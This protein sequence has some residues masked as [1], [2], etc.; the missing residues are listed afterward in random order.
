MTELLK[1]KFES[2]HPGSSLYLYGSHALG[3]AHKLSDIDLLVLSPQNRT[4]QQGFNRDE[5][6]SF[7][8]NYLVVN[9]EAYFGDRNPMHYLSSVWDEI[10]HIGVRISGDRHLKPQMKTEDRVIVDWMRL[11]IDLALIRKDSSPSQICKTF[12]SASLLVLAF[13]EK[14]QT[15]GIFSIGILIHRLLAS[16]PIKLTDPLWDMIEESGVLWR[17]LDHKIFNLNEDQLKYWC[18][19]LHQRFFSLFP[20][21]LQLMQFA[22]VTICGHSFFHGHPLYREIN[23]LKIE[24]GYLIM[25]DDGEQFIKNLHAVY[26]HSFRAMKN[27]GQQ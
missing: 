21:V 2:S 6:F 15:G 8:L 7:P 23:W 13:E 14:I 22:P 18:A 12:A 17:W 4:V 20:R 16:G 11:L 9:E 25:E 1:L 10:A 26:R 27:F 24:N 19:E 3:L 5:S